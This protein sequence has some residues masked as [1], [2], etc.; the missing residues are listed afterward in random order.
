MEIDM[1]QT[2]IGRLKELKKREA[3]IAVKDMSQEE[4]NKIRKCLDKIDD[5][6]AEELG[7]GADTNMEAEEGKTGTV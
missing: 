4:R 3:F 7:N 2:A 6:A 1:S 5:A